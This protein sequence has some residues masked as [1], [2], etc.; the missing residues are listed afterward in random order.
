MLS[1]NE[2]EKI[3]KYLLRE[4]IEKY[5]TEEQKKAKKEQYPMTIEYILT[6]D[7]IIDFE[8]AKENYIER[9]FSTLSN[10]ELK[11]EGEL[12]IKVNVKEGNKSIEIELKRYLEQKNIKITN[13]RD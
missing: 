6:S 11:S 5:L 8:R 7:E 2:K 3:K 10:Y 1:L 4:I 12:E 13:L 9:V